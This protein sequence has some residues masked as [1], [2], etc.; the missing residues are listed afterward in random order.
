[1]RDLVHK[2]HRKIGITAA[3]FVILLALSGLMLNHTEQLDLDNQHITNK[4]LLNWYNIQPRN[5]IKSFIADQHWLSWIDG[6]LYLNQTEIADSITDLLGVVSNGQ[7]L[8]VALDT[9]LL[10]L[11]HDGEIVEKIS[12]A[13]G[14]PQGINTIGLS[15]QGDIIIATTDSH[16]RIDP[17]TLNWQPQNAAPIKPAVAAT[18]PKAL[19]E[20]LLSYY[21]GQGLALERIILDLHSGRILGQAGVLLVDFMACLFL[22]LSIS[23]IWMWY[24][25]KQN[26]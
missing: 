16:Y 10:I 5:P 20:Q 24:K 6:H 12:T 3:A 2:W 25:Y 19:H 7:Y 4:L 15:P 9:A 22:L 14:L 1:M 18:L 13:H 21:R 26:R 23:G 17:E 11:T 8:F